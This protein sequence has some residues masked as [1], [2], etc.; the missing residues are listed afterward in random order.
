ME[1]SVNSWTGG[2]YS[3]Q[4]NEEG[5]AHGEGYFINKQNTHVFRGKFMENTLFGFWHYT[6]QNKEIMITEKKRDLDPDRHNT[7]YKPNGE[8]INTVYK[9]SRIVS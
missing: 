7:V 9:G 6:Y 8:I 4:I 1:T 3:G 5:Q 2:L